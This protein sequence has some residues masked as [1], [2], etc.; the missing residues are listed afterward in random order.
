MLGHLMQM[1]H[2]K[3]IAP[4]RRNNDE[5]KIQISDIYE[6]GFNK[7]FGLKNKCEGASCKWGFIF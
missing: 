5:E 7:L 4:F 3:M 1:Y 6:T 2:H